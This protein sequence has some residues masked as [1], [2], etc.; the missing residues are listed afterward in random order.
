[1]SLN[2]KLSVIVLVSVLSQFAFGQKYTVYKKKKSYFGLSAGFNFSFPKVTDHY[3]VL[4]SVGSASAENF[5]KNYDKFGKNSGA[6][7]GARYSY[8]FTNSIS[9]IAGFGYESL[10]FKYFTQYAWADTINN[11]SFER[12]MHHLQKISYFNF[13]L[14]L[15]WDMSNGQLMP[16]VQGG[17]FMN[18][19][20]QAKKEILYDNTIDGE[21]TENQISSSGIVP[22]SDH[23][24]KFNMGLMGGIGISYYTKRITYGVESNFSYG[25]LKVV[26]DKNRY[27]D[28]TGFALNYLDVLDQLKLSNWNVNFTV[29]IPINHAVSLN[30]LR[31]RRY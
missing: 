14:L 21:E 16:Y 19:R 18:F 4:S 8:S 26:N 2:A 29:S 24:R 3:T 22:L 17:I 7:F 31:R 5:E 25:F 6:Q 11:Q 23:I 13:P 1:M 10:G 15:R 12:E 28:Y 27:A 20:H 30:I 9:F